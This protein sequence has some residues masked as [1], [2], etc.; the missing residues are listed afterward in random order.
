M[1]VLLPDVMLAVV[2]FSKL[3]VCLLLCFLLILFL[4]INVHAHGYG[5]VGVCWGER[6]RV[7][8]DVLAGECIFLKKKV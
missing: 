1:F 6:P 8:G 4:P 7:A 3:C 5:A 2:T